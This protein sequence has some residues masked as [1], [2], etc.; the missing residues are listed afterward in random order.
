M[1]G[2]VM[3][4]AVT[5]DKPNSAAPVSYNFGR[6]KFLIFFDQ[7]KNHI[8]VIQNPFS[9]VLGGAGIQ[10]A[11]L[12]VENNV[13]AVVTNKIGANPYRLLRCAEIKIFRGEGLNALKSV[14]MLVNNKLEIIKTPLNNTAD[15]TFDDP[16]D[17]NCGKNEEFI[18]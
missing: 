1:R 17:L 7:R 5:T 2:A 18:K 14:N 11:K 3:L 6:A 13:D 8:K 9:D 16:L 12:V 10:L 4:I 15:N